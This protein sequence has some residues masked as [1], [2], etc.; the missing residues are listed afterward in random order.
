MRGYPTNPVAEPALEALSERYK[1]IR[2]FVLAAESLEQ[3]ATSFPANRRDAAWR[4][5]ELYEDKVKDPAKAKAAY[6]LVPA[7]SPRY[8]DAQKKLR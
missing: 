6:A 3:L 4:A 1:D 5:G 2:Q 8:R 7:T